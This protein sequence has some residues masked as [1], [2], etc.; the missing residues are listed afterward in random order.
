MSLSRSRRCSLGLPGRAR[1]SW[2]TQGLEKHSPESSLFPRLPEQPWHRT[3]R[4]P[5]HNALVCHCRT[6]CEVPQLPNCQLSVYTPSRP[7]ELRVWTRPGLCLTPVPTTT[8]PR[9]HFPA[10]QQG[11]VSGGGVGWPQ[12]PSARTELA[13]LGRCGPAAVS[14]QAGTMLCLIRLVCLIPVLQR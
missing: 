12:V 2:D 7:T 10:G 8:G 6:V 3:G 9:L 5:G 11:T 14:C 1:R 13:A 4:V